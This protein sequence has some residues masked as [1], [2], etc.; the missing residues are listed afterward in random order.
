MSILKLESGGP[1]LPLLTIEQCC[2]QWTARNPRMPLG[3]A[4]MN[5]SS[6]A[7]DAIAIA[8]LGTELQARRSHCRCLVSSS[9]SWQLVL[10]AHGKPHSQQWSAI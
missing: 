5:R 6:K 9:V 2:A 4:D 1:G 3:N 7:W 8:A 10:S